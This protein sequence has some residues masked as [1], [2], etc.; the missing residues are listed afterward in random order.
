MGEVDA[1]AAVLGSQDDLDGAG[2]GRE[3]VG[4][5]E[6]PAEHDAVGWIDDLEVSS[7]RGA[8]DIDSETA[9]LGGLELGVLTQPRHHQLCGGEILE[10]HSRRDTTAVKINA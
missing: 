2:V 1:G 6:A 8:G 4:S 3:V 9:A 7:Y 5:G 10:H